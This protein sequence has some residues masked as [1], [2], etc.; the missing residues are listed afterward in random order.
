MGAGGL[1]WYVQVTIFWT[2]KTKSC[3]LF[4]PFWK[5]SII[6][7]AQQGEK[8][9]AFPRLMLVHILIDIV[10]NISLTV[11]LQLNVHRYVWR[12]LVGN[13]YF[14]PLL[15]VSHTDSLRVEEVFSLISFVKIFQKTM[16]QQE[17]F[18]HFSEKNSSLAFEFTK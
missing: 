3:S 13:T 10:L 9:Y 15:I 7:H 14:P 17:I 5:D 6:L 11:L 18:A 1:R 12:L 2:V 4:I 8:H 16:W